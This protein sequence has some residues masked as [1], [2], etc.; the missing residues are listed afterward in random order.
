[1]IDSIPWSE[2]LDAS[3]TQ[4][5]TREGAATLY[6]HMDLAIEDWRS[7]DTAGLKEELLMLLSIADPVDLDVQIFADTGG[8]ASSRVGGGRRRRSGSTVIRVVFTG[9]DAA[10]SRVK[11]AHL[12]AI[13]AAR[14]LPQSLS[15]FPIAGVSTEP[16][17]WTDF[18]NEDDP[19]SGG[20]DDESGE[21]LLGCNGTAPSAIYCV[22]ASGGQPWFKRGD[23]NGQNLESPCT[24]ADGLVCRNSANSEG[25][26]DYM[27]QLLC[28]VRAATSAP[29]A[30]PTASPT[31]A[32]REESDP[33][34]AL[35]IIGNT[36]ECGGPPLAEGMAGQQRLFCDDDRLLSASSAT[37]RVELLVV[38]TAEVKC[39][40]TTTQPDQVVVQQAWAITI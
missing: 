37:V 31:M 8:G 5:P 34:V 33:V 25:C 2:D 19:A 12:A 17:V 30:P 7:T 26:D 32:P 4:T 15:G 23:G 24:L 14:E 22:E 20:G 6:I 29:T 16:G 3:S 9:T 27:V 38:P 21:V 1:M 39:T 36:S 10:E 40:L 13:F 28:P 18:F 35:A 11:A